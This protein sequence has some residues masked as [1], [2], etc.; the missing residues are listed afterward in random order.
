MSGTDKPFEHTDYDKMEKENIPYTLDLPNMRDSLGKYRT[1]SLFKEFNHGRI[2]AT[3]KPFDP[4]FTLRDFDYDGLPSFKRMYMEAS[5][6]SEYSFAME[7]LGSWEHW[8]KLCSVGFF[9]PYIEKWRKELVLKLK[10]DGLIAL[11]RLAGNA[12]SEAQRLQ[13]AKFLADEGFVPD[14]RVKRGRP[15]KEEV[16]GEMNRRLQ[17]LSDV[18]EDLD[19][20][21]PDGTA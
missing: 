17:H 10:S 15:S 9:K 3:G 7:T 14:K 20:I 13:A 8:E 5:D 19:R 18:E 12:K 16:E 1:R 6:P 2:E 11:T 21:Q 4:V